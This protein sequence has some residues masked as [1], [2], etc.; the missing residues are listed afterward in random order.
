MSFH[1][2]THPNVEGRAGGAE[3]ILVYTSM[4]FYSPDN[5]FYLTYALEVQMINPA[6]IKTVKISNQGSNQNIL[7]GCVLPFEP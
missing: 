4:Q 5:N 6:H 3:S 2:G 7:L 1:E